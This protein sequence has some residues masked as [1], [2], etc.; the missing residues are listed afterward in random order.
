MLVLEGFPMHAQELELGNPAAMKG[1][2]NSYSEEVMPLFDIFRNQLYVA[3]GLHKENTGGVRS[4]SDIWRY[5]PYRDVM[6]NPGSPW[7][8]KENNAVIGISRDTVYLLNSYKSRTGIAFSTNRNG[9]W[10]D[11][12]ILPISGIIT[13]GPVGF[14]LDHEAGILVISMVGEDTFGQED[15]YISVRDQFGKW[16]I[17]ENL[18]PGI[19]TPGAEIS[20]F[21]YQDQKTLF[22]SSTAHESRGS[23]DIFYSRRLYDSWYLWST[24]K[25]VPGEIN[26]NYFEAYF[27]AYDSLCYYSSNQGGESADIYQ[28][29]FKLKERKLLTV[30]P[31]D[32]ATSDQF[33]LDVQNYTRMDSSAL[34]E[35]FGI[36]LQAIIQ[37]EPNTTRLK[38]VSAELLYFIA[39]KLVSRDS[40][41]I[42]VQYPIINENEENIFPLRARKVSDFLTNMGISSRRILEEE[43][44]DLN[45]ETQ[46]VKLLFSSY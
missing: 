7:N 9:K 17:P 12:L 44:T 38:P 6:E 41:I 14:Y 2:L 18:G 13:E 32:G 29:S 46:G 45:Q 24:V 10:S 36:N 33:T 1:N 37:F 23:F 40:S 4:G 20:P 21:L 11:P 26:T 22:F 28:A 34:T 15:L 8:T 30:L 42:H 3:R 25:P 39:N 35:L 19:N 43:S 16:S 31:E 5:D 27:S